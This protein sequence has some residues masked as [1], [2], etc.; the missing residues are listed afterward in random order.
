MMRVICY[1]P[2]YRVDFSRIDK[3]EEF[4]LKLFNYLLENHR[5]SFDL[6]RGYRD[7]EFILLLFMHVNVTMF[8]Y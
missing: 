3:A 5:D 4:G 6:E 2:L 8:Q 7:N 1:F